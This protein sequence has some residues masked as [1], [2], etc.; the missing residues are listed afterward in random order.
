MKQQ[1]DSMQ[2]QMQDKEGTIE[3]LERQ[4]VQAGIRNK[5]MQGS[6]EINKKVAETK[7]NYD[8]EYNETKTLQQQIRQDS[9]KE[10]ENNKTRLD[11][12]LNSLPIR[13]KNK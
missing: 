4:L 8:K 10:F 13:E 11:E 3:T 5:T 2:K 9:K 7:A 6:M 1:I 12:L